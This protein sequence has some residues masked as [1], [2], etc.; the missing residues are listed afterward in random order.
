MDIL[1]L[2]IIW[3]TQ[4]NFDAYSNKVKQMAVIMAG[5]HLFNIDV[6]N[7]WGKKRVINQLSGKSGNSQIACYE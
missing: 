4:A 5:K 3:Y 2:L 6:G 1:L 7:G